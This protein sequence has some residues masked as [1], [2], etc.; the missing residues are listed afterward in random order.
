MQLPNKLYLYKNSTLVLLPI[1]LKEIKDEPILVLDL[2][3]KVK[4]ELKEST[5]FLSAM[6]VLYAINMVDITEEGEVF[7]CL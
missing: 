4:C 1:V 7:K 6:D 3:K 2:Y 5:D